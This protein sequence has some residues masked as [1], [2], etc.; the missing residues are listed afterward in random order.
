MKKNGARACARRQLEPIDLTD[1]A[2]YRAD[3]AYLKEGQDVL[4]PSTATLRRDGRN[5]RGPAVDMDDGVIVVPHVANRISAW[6]ARVADGVRLGHEA[7]GGGG[8]GG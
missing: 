3:E 4:R 6:A 8:D 2:P 5:R 1:V 7:P